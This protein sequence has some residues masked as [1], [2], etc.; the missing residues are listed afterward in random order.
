MDGLE[1]TRSVKS[2]SPDT[3]SILITAYGNGEISNSANALGCLAYLEKPFDIDVLLHYSSIAL[4]KVAK[5]SNP[6]KPLDLN[7]ILRIYMKSKKDTVLSIIA[8]EHA[9][10]LVVKNGRIIHAQYKT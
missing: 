6:Q 2:V 5:P 10:Y 9:G 4:E 8:D 3:H 7:K 1:L